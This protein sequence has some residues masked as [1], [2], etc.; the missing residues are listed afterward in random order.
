VIA[1]SLTQW[2][3]SGH[4]SRGVAAPVATLALLMLWC[5]TGRASLCCL[6][7]DARRVTELAHGK[8]M[9][10]HMVLVEPPRR[11]HG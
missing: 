6:R 8:P 1:G 4:H 2:S 3:R 10:V 5:S 9:A 11:A 7:S